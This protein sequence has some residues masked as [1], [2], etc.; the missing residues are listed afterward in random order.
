MDVPSLALELELGALAVLGGGSVPLS[1]HALAL[2]FPT[3]EYYA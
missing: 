2:K 1:E 3:A